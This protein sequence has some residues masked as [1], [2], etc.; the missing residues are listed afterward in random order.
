M[1]ELI[2]NYMVHTHHHHQHHQI[3]NKKKE[4]FSVLRVQVIKIEL[5]S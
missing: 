3:I 4:N 1:L 2:K 5:Y